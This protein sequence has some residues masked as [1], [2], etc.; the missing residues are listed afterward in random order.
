MI[1]A[2]IRIM[3]YFYESEH[4][5][6]WEYDLNCNGSCGKTFNSAS[7]YVLLT[8]TFSELLVGI[9][10]FFWILGTK[11]VITWRSS[12]YSITGCGEPRFEAGNTTLST[13]STV[14]TQ[15]NSIYF[16]QNLPLDNRQ[17]EHYQYCASKPLL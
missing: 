16:P 2:V 12:W 7:Y 4:R 10:A 8:R 1:P 15:D 6:Q 9:T 11:T 5:Q 14:T 17:N 13:A 3:C